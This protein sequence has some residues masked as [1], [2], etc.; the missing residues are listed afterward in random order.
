MTLF[1][2]ASLLAS[3]KGP[4][5]KSSWVSLDHGSGPRHL[6]GVHLQGLLCHFHLMPMGY[7]DELQL[8]YSI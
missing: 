8:V 3:S 6:H 1:S 5:T 2:Y 7:P 4:S